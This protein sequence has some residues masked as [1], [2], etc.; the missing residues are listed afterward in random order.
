MIR[1]I[2]A[3]NYRCLRCVDVYLDR[4][5]ILVGPNASGK[6]T[7]CDAIAFLSDLVRDGLE[8]A[9]A[10]RSANFADLVWGRPRENT[11]FELAVEFDIPEDLRVRLP[12]GTDF[13]VFRYQVALRDEDDG[14]RI[15]SERGI[16][17]PRR[18]GTRSVQRDLFPDPPAPPATILVEGG[19][20]GSR[21]VLAKSTEGTDSF[22]V[23]THPKAGKGW[24]TTIAFGRCRPAL[25][26]LPE[27]S[28]FPVATH[29]RRT[30]ETG[31][32]RLSLDPP[33]MR[34]PSPPQ[35]GRRGLAADGSNLP[36]VVRRLRSRNPGEFDG[37]LGRAKGA[38][39]GLQDI[40]VVERPDDRH[41]YLLLRDA[42]GVEVPSWSASDGTLRLLA[43]TLLPHLPC[44]DGIADMLLIGEPEN[45]IHPGGLEAVR[46]SLSS[47]ERSQ[48][49]L[50]T[51]AP[52]LLRQVRPE[53]VLC[54]ARTC[55]GAIDILSGADHPRVAER[56][57][58][59]EMDALF[60]GGL[61]DQG[62]DR[63]GPQP[64]R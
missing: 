5:H 62:G 55:E 1:R 30:L 48:V 53:S 31:V 61:L 63:P 21:T 35:Y 8:A 2:Q 28:N 9:V 32:R 4:Y 23:E 15:H 3:L 22:N 43:L 18:A 45:G 16:L 27:S 47:I 49:L 58:P 41:A 50:S 40:R 17:Q 25:G 51:H 38:V 20:P 57:D 54:F 46:R 56:E 14:P 59:A 26:N 12:P 19:K 36:W 42:S 33:A 64:A 44:R 6:S 60:A 7:L 52:E 11:G 37:W 13:R 34:R 29:V 10:R 39:P 24:V